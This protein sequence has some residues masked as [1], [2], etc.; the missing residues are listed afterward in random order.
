MVSLPL[1]GKGGKEEGPLPT[2]QAFRQ[3]V[4]GTAPLCTHARVYVCA[5]TP[6]YAHTPPPHCMLGPGALHSPMTFRKM[7]PDAST[8]FSLV[9]RS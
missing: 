7:L 3:V 5:H 1:K 2:R 8:T 9:A 4:P 6:T